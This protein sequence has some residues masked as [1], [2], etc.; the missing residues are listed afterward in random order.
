MIAPQ[1]LGKWRRSAHRLTVDLNYRA[2][3][4]MIAPKGQGYPV[5]NLVD[6]SKNGL[7][8]DN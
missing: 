6:R 3:Y 2:N 7:I 4:L 8:H 5:K 1:A